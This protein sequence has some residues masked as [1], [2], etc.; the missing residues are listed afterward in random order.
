MEQLKEQIEARQSYLT[1][2]KE[3]KEK[4]LKTAPEGY[5]RICS[6]GNRTQYYKREDSKDFNGAYIR[7]S[8]VKLARRLAQKEYDKKV[9]SSTEKELQAI[10]KYLSSAPSVSPEQIYENLHK[11]RKKIVVPIEKPLEEYVQEWESV[12][13]RGKT[14]EEGAPQMYTAKGERVRSKSEVIIA[15]S[16]YREGIPYRYEC[17]LYLEGGTVFYP[18]FTVLNAEMRKEMYWEHFGLMDDAEYVE[19]AI[20]KLMVYEQNGIF[21]GKNLILTYE[22]KKCPLNQRRIKECIRQYL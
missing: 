2:L 17:P 3:E 19:G 20:Y 14:F 13:Y 22:T 7:D 10:K 11:E 4:A 1:Y 6:H 5:L 12:S 21:L 8:D 9:L 16:L 18:D 15:D